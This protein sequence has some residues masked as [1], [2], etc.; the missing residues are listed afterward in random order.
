MDPLPLP[1]DFSGLTSGKDKD[2][3]D[4]PVHSM[5]VES[6]DLKYEG[7]TKEELI[8]ELYDARE[9]IQELSRR[10]TDAEQLDAAM[11]RARVGL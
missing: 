2:K 7:M 11:E 5:A 4:Q 6:M 8:R 1:Q 10:N 3:H 9:R